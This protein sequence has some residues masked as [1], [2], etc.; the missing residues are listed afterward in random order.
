ML[1]LC[2][3]VETI[4]QPCHGLQLE[5]PFCNWC[6]TWLPLHIISRA[7]FVCMD[8]LN[9]L[10]MRSVYILSNQIFCAKCTSTLLGKDWA[11]DLV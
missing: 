6:H 8:H 2:N 7:P 4:P 9:D 1:M 3:H 10:S 5:E 11:P